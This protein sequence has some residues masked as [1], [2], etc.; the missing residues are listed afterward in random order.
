MIKKVGEVCQKQTTVE[1][2]VHR[3]SAWCRRCEFFNGMIEGKL[4]SCKCH[5]A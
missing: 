1:T 4:I 3:G 5:E 2:E